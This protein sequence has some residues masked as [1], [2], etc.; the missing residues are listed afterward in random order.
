MSGQSRQLVVLGAITGVHGIG[1][2]VKVK[3]FTGDPYAIGDYGPLILGDT[4]KRLEIAHMQPHKDIF[5]MRFEGVDGR[6]AAEALKGLELKIERDVLPD[7]E[8]GE[9]YFADLVGLAV[10]R[11]DDRTIGKV[12]DVVNFGAGD[13]LE[14][15]FDGHK[16]TEFLAFNDATVP[17][18]DMAGGFVV[19]DPPD[20]LLADEKE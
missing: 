6:D 7:A 10:R 19:I 17:V 16:K 3:S 20:W 2:M 4:G 12:V 9:F 8:D 18:V 14:I 11:D 13:L 1:G 5:L 15:E